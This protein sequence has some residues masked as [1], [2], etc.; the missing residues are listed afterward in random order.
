VVG[1]VEW[2]DVVD[3]SLPEGGCDWKGLNGIFWFE[4]LFIQVLSSQYTMKTFRFSTF[5]HQKETF[6]IIPLIL[7][8]TY[9]AISLYC[10]H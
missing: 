9:D 1:R 10:S 4:G 7:F 6:K 3:F 2:I 8:K 5:K